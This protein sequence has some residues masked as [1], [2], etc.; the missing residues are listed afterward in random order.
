[1]TIENTENGFIIEK[2]FIYGSTS[3]DKKLINLGETIGIDT[4]YENLD[5]TLIDY[6]GEYDIKGVIIKC[7]IGK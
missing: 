3:P 7:F 6:P 2:K 5:Y 4:R 1:M